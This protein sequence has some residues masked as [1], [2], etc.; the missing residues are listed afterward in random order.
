MPYKARL[1]EGEDRKRRKPGYRVTNWREYNGSLKKR[2]KISLYFPGG[3]LR[4]QFITASPYVRGVS[5]RLPLYTR[6]YVELI[7]TFYRLLGWGMRQISGYLEDYWASQGLDIPV[8]SFGHLC[9]LFAALDVKVTQRRER[10]ARRLAR[11]EDTSV[12]IDS[13]GMSFG[14]AS[15][16]YEQKYGKKA[17]KTPWRKMHLSIDA[18]MNVHAIAVTGTDVSDSEGM[19]RVLPADIPVDRV[20]ADGAYYSIERTEALSRSGVLPVIPPPSHAVVHGEEQTQWH[21]KVVGY[22]R[23]KG[24]Y[25]FHKKYGYGQRSLVE[26]QIS[27]IKRCIGSTLLTR[28][29]GSQ[30]SESAI[31]A[32]ILNLWNSFGR[33]VSFKNG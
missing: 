2:G 17:A 25:A 15:E 1:K 14:R 13:T 5:G 18:D 26:A 21:D 32:N 30:E 7:Y 11:G 10:L 23:E 16:W 19:D 31:I 12:I 22:I 9:D 4:S 33:P 6:P 29:I 27:R 8:P 20:I 28:K 24:I 3:D